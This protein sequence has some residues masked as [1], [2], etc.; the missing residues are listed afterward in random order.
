MHVKTFL[1]CEGQC[2]CTKCYNDRKRNTIQAYN[3]VIRCK[4]LVSITHQIYFYNLRLIEMRLRSFE[5]RVQIIGGFNV[6]Y[7]T[8]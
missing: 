3:S 5:L 1:L 4:L 7:V 6:P 8:E 2:S